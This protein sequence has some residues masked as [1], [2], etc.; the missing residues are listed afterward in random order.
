MKPTPVSEQSAKIIHQMQSGVEKP[1]LKYCLR[2]EK[3]VRVKE[4]PIHGFSWCSENVNY[5]KN[6][7]RVAVTILVGPPW[8]S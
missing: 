5:D 4:R 7:L 3:A 1:G 2:S 8:L 6:K